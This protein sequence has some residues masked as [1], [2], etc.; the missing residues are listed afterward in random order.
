MRN[1][2][3]AFSLHYP[4]SEGFPGGANGREPTRQCRKHK[5]LRFNLGSRRFP[6]GGHGNPL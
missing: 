6:G 4:V 5:R 3:R 2:P 1:S